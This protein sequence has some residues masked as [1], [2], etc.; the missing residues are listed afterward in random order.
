M[1]DDRVMER[2]RVIE[3]GAS[4]GEFVD[5]LEG[6]PLGEQMDAA[7]RAMV[8]E[9]AARSKRGPLSIYVCSDDG[10]AVLRNH[11]AFLLARWLGEHAPGTLLIDCDFTAVGMSGIVPER[12]SLG[13]LDLLLYGSSLR[14]ITQSTESGVDV[15]GA[16]SFPVPRRLP[17]SLDAFDD[18]R[19]YLLHRS[20]CVIFCGPAYG[21]DGEVHPLMRH[22]DLPVFVGGREEGPVA[23]LSEAILWDVR[24][25]G[26]PSTTPPAGEREVEAPAGG[27]AKRAEPEPAPAAEDTPQPERI[28]AE[29]PRRRE[30]E[31]PR[32]EPEPEPSE[33]PVIDEETEISLGV[34]SATST[35]PIIITAV[36]A[37][38]L[39]VFFIWWLYLTKSFREGGG[40]TVAEK[41][42]VSQPVTEPKN[43]ADTR[44]TQPGET[45]GPSE[46]VE[47]PITGQT[48]EAEGPGNEAAEGQTQASK[49]HEVEL[50]PGIA[51]VDDLREFANQYL[52]H[53]SSFRSIDRANEDAATLET[54]GYPIVVAR[55]DLEAKG[56]W[57][58]VY[59]GP[60]A[61]R[62]DARSVKI[63]LDEDS[64][65]KFTRIT[66]VPQ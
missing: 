33:P 13:F 45:E 53:V 3:I 34:K 64:S 23:G 2:T 21:D 11:F 9:L 47:G 52:I 57:Y 59:V 37:V 38:V 61:S 63:R 55:V 25:V 5:A 36:L 50:K 40:E 35:I 7:V 20:P 16:G 8:S 56:V 18:A 17:F 27:A 1:K 26:R 48:L 65:V 10:D 41:T 60:I 24:I 46:G 4:L 14:V 12:D 39:I 54:R 62:D 6:R 19:R 51:V 66:K 30:R 42:P 44:S 31:A 58:R 15:I 49:Q 29:A 32:T 28:R 43:E 22:V